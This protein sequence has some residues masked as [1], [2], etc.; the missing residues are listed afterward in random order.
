[1]LISS[2]KKKDRIQKCCCDR[3]ESIF[4]PVCSVTQ[5]CPALYNPMDCSLPGSSIHGIFQAIILEWFA[6]SYSRGLPRPRTRTH[7]SCGSLH[8]QVDCLPLAPHGS[9][10]QRLHF[11]L[12]L[13][14]YLFTGKFFHDP[15]TCEGI[16]FNIAS[17]SGRSLASSF[18]LSFRVRF[19]K[20]VGVL[21]IIRESLC[22]LGV[23]SLN[24][25]S[26]HLDPSLSLSNSYL[27][28][29][30]WG[31]SFDSASKFRILKSA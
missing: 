14:N 3:N 26:V 10:L 25:E 15:K 20:S 18:S 24:L 21:F 31:S 8:W 22:N 2:R 1:M 23:M 6:T 13:R 30:A 16:E 11:E 7:V 9:S 12:W 4:C 27:L 29:T 17:F 19:Q 5:S 28:G